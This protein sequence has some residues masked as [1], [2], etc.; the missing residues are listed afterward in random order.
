MAVAVASA[1]LL[2]T[3]VQ[4][5]GA[6]DSASTKPTDQTA[7]IDRAR[8]VRRARLASSESAH[9]GVPLTRKTRRNAM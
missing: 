5:T 1:E 8:A 4:A 7:E 9:A 6:R 2:P 3:V